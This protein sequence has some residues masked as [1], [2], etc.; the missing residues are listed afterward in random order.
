MTYV[1]GCESGFTQFGQD[2]KPVMSKTRD[3]G[4]MQINQVHWQRAKDLGLDIFYSPE[5]NIKMGRIIME[6]SGLQAWSCFKN[7]GRKF[8]FWS[9]NG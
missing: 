1:I 7:L 5:D 9:P 6:E 3:V 8:A 4:V 2:G